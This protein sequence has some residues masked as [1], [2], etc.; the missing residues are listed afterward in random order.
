MKTSMNLNVSVL[1]ACTVLLTACGSVDTATT[2]VEQVIEEPV[3]ENVSVHDPSVW[4][5]GEEK[6][7]IGS[8]LQFAK[9]EDLMKWEPLSQSVPTTNLFEDV[10]EELAEDFDYARSDTLWASDIIQLEDG[11]YYLYYCLCEGS[12]PLSTLGLAVADEIEGPYKKVQTLL[13]SGRGTAPDGAPYDATIHPNAIDPHIFYDHEGELWMVYGSYSG[14]IF[15][16]PL[17]KETGLPTE[18]NYGT[19]LMGGNHSRIEAPYIY[20]EEETG[21]Y[22]LFTSFGGLDANGS[23]NIRVARSK[24]PDGPYEDRNGQDMIDAK[25]ED[26]SFFDDLAIES[27]GTKLI[28]NYLWDNGEEEYGYV[29]PGHNSVY[30]DE[31]LEQ[32]FILFHTRFPGMGEVH[33]V[34]V[35]T[36]LFNEDGWPMIAPL[37][38]AGEREEE[39]ALGDIQ[40]EFMFIKDQTAIVPDAIV[41]KEVVIDGKNISGEFKGTVDLGENGLATIKIDGETIK[42]QFLPQWDEHTKKQ[43]ITF[44]GLTEEGTAFMMVRK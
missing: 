15:I 42:G 8:H 29:S 7:V 9:T 18:E 33:E 1:F 21:Y 22:Y 20:Y 23:Y 16:L 26:G 38:Y 36:L 2:S 25:G 24:T 40:G 37:R 3:F 39:V 28:G 27:Y 10:Y 43:T 44:T 12:S 13:T 4:Q 34:R 6:Y 11:R 35:H 14:G 19:K 32:S 31:E 5:D 17:D 30:Y 41:S